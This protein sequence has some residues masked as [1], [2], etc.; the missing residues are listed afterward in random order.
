MFLNKR[1]NK[2]NTCRFQVKLARN[3]KKPK[4]EATAY[5]ISTGGM[6]LR[7]GHD[8]YQDKPI[9]IRSEKPDFKSFE[10]SWETAYIGKIRW[11]KKMETGIDYGVGIEYLTKGIVPQANGKGLNQTTCSMCG[12]LTHENIHKTADGVELCL[13]CFYKV[14]A[15]E[16]GITKSGL[17]RF[18]SGNVL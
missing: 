6:F 8:L 7:S 9:Y 10:L 13:S 14:G 4:L 3:G 15:M 12:N 11:I 16:S 17:M 2:R 5:N 18:L 1:Q